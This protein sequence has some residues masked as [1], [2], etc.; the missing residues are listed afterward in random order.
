MQ[1]LNQSWRFALNSLQA[2]TQKGIRWTKIK[3]K[4]LGNKEVDGP[5]ASRMSKI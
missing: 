5:A 3:E 1:F 2:K 4:L